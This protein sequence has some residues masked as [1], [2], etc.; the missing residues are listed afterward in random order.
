[1][2]P[3][4]NSEK[5][6][7][8]MIYL[9]ADNNLSQ[10]MVWSLK[11][12]QNAYGNYIV[13]PDPDRPLVMAQIDPWGTT[14]RFYDFD[15]A[16]PQKPGQRWTL[17]GADFTREQ[18]S[19]VR[20]S[21]EDLEASASPR[22]VARFFNKVRDYERR[23]N[24]FILS[25]HGSGALGDFL[26]DKNPENYLSIKALAKSVLA[27]V[28]DHQKEKID[29]L[30]LDS[31]LMSM[32]EIGYEIRKYVHYLIGAEGFELGNGWP[33]GAVLGI[34]AENPRLVPKE[35]AKR[36]VRCYSEYY[37]DYE[38]TGVSTD[39]SACCLDN[40]EAVAGAVKKLVN[41]LLSIL[42]SPVGPDLVV[43][44]HWEAQSYKEDQYV[45][46]WD[47]CFLL[48]NRILLLEQQC[49]SAL[50]RTSYRSALRACQAVVDSVEKA[51]V[52]S[53]YC[54]AAFQHSH[55]LSIYFP[56]SRNP[57]DLTQ[58]RKLAFATVTGWGRFLDEYLTCTQR[59][60]R[61][62]GMTRCRPKHYLRPANELVS[63]RTGPTSARTSPTSARTGPTSARIYPLEISPMKNPPDGFCSDP[64]QRP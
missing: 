14:P 17:D 3:Q 58:Y 45:D 25:G 59:A 9:A 41:P 43:R 38:M 5:P 42:K 16:L 2:A 6:W 32:A 35:L 18:D 44:A 55:G 1:M 33:Y 50:R 31:C 11:E 60:R 63:I 19:P 48:R 52:L 47:F 8:L 15:R 37:R 28:V 56:W 53:C 49:P 7:N 61:E 23:S 20:G 21:K 12:I 46:L 26:L 24:F 54:G 4:Q 10:E 29:I 40:I 39:L 22:I 62:K 64:C 51:T 36:A 27:K 57:L 34:L 13:N 30:G